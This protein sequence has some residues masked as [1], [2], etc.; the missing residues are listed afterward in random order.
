MGK[1]D[2][3]RSYTT[4]IKLLITDIYM[5]YQPCM[6]IVSKMVWAISDL[7]A[8]ISSNSTYG[9]LTFL[10]F[11]HYMDQYLQ[12]NLMVAISLYIDPFFTDQ[13]LALFALRQ[14]LIGF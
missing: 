4:C 6:R 2:P 9:E 8:K 13:N 12:L 10:T 11:C 7:V 1:L 3:K 5:Y 14:E